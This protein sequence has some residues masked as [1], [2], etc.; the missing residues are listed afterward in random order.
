MRFLISICLMLAA[1]GL[2]AADSKQPVIT[3]LTGLVDQ[4][5]EEFV[6]SGEDAMQ[7]KA[8]LRASGFSPDNFARFVGERV[9]ARG[10]LTTEGDRRVLTVRRLEDLKKVPKTE[11]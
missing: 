4:Q 6:L 5:G 10:E 3:T 9:E 2:S 1:A 8:V 7:T 11:R